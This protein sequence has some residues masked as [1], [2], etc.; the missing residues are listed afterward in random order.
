MS[1]P[2]KAPVEFTAFMDSFVAELIAMP[3]E[4]VLDG[5]SAQDSHAQGMKI[6]E[7]AKKEAGRRRLAAARVQVESRKSRPVADV[8]E[9]LDIDQVRRFLLN[10]QNDERFTMAARKLGELSD[11]DVLRLYRQVRSLQEGEAGSGD[12]E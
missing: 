3:D 10:A 6:F 5:S 12:K 9:T 7:A 2:M 8:S 1:K 11:E 4:Q